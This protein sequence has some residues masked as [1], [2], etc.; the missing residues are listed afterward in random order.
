MAKGHPILN[1]VAYSIISFFV[2]IVVIFLTLFLAQ[3]VFI[4]PQR[5]F[6]N[7]L[8]PSELELMIVSIS[9]VVISI[10]ISFVIYLLGTARTRTELSVWKETRWLATSRE[11][12]RRLYDGA[13]VPYLML[14]TKKKFMNQTRPLFVSSE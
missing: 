12:F 4:N 10:S 8:S 1:H 14:T 3:D 2:S 5:Y 13:P 9:G 11:E 6:S 7:N